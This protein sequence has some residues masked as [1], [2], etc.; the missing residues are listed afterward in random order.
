MLEYLKTYLGIHSA[1]T[2][3]DQKINDLIEIAMQDLNIAGVSGHQRQ[4][5]IFK[6]ERT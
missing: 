3:Y 1:V 4:K 6:G 2:I 5:I